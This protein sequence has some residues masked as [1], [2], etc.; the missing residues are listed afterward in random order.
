MRF[1]FASRWVHGQLL[2]QGA[3]GLT[4]HL[5]LTFGIDIWHRQKN[6]LEA[7][8]KVSSHLAL[9]SPCLRATLLRWKQ[10]AFGSV[11]LRNQHWRKSFG[12]WACQVPILGR[13]QAHHYHH[14]RLCACL[15]EFGCPFCSI[16]S[17]LFAF[18][19]CSCWFVWT[20][21]AGRWLLL[22]WECHSLPT[23]KCGR[24]SCGGGSAVN[25]LW[26]AAFGWSCVASKSRAALLR[27]GC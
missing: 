24:V 9:T 6:I 3:L 15:S 12:G 19:W 1:K 26:F 21:V 16:V 20:P 7:K 4:R 11:C 14:R 18:V 2:W 23:K 8:N 10:S 13:R 25:Y 22:L 27:V 5:A 17:L